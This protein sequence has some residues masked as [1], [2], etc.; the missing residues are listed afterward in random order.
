MIKEEKKDF[1]YLADKLN[2]CHITLRSRCRSAFE[3]WKSNENRRI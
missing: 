3:S 2:R 1:F